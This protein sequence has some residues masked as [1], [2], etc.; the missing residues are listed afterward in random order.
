DHGD[1][2]VDDRPLPLQEF[3]NPGEHFLAGDALDGGV[4]VREQKADVALPRGAQERV[5][6][7]VQEDVA[8]G[9]AQGPAGM[10]DLDAAQEKL[11]SGDQFVNVPAVPDGHVEG[12]YNM[13]DGAAPQTRR[14]NRG[15]GLRYRAGDQRAQDDEHREGA[16][17]RQGDV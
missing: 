10:G 3:E 13:A 8:V 2:D 11:P 15:R 6:H 17:H 9:M 5:D 12:Q 7:R 1:V 4:A 16:D 14:A